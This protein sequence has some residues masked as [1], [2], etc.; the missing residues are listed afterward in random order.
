MVN[1]INAY[2][3]LENIA[4]NYN[5]YKNMSQSKVSCVIKAD[6]YG[7]GLEKVAKKLISN[8]CDTF[9]VATVET[10]INL[11]KHIGIKP[12]IL[13]IN[14]YFN[15][16]E[17][18]YS[19]FN[20][21]PVI[22]TFTQ[23]ENFKNS[24]FQKKC[25]IG[26]DTGMNRL[27]FTLS[28]LDNLVASIIEIDIEGYMSHLC[29]ADE[30]FDF[31]KKQKDN[32][33]KMLYALPSAV[34]SFAA[35]EGSFINN[36][37]HYDMLRIG[38]G[39]YGY[40]NNDTNKALK[41]ALSLSSTVLQVKEIK[42]GETV[43]YGN[44]WRAMRNSKIATVFGGYADGIKRL[45][46]NNGQVYYNE[47]IIPIIGRVSMD[48]FCIDVTNIDIKEGDEIFLFKNTQQINHLANTIGTIEYEILTSCKGRIN[49][50]Y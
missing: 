32:L 43:G 13:I 3:N 8:G 34:V 30:N 12:K 2:V 16:Y 6:A 28:M 46:S 15:N 23:L 1:S 25:W 40:V 4:H 29:T 39:L 41:P 24:N 45:L 21:I 17:N 14:G 26:L 19:E 31:A 42:Q 20:L 11:R 10:G 50:I 38:I 47:I 36:E 48:S 44:T 27:G 37:Y 33:D 35:S 7:M 18:D 22:S 5:T 49:F 9:W